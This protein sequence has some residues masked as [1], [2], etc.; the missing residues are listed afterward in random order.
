VASLSGL[1]AIAAMPTAIMAPEISPPGRCA[2]K[3]SAPPAVPITSVSSTWRALVRLG[4][5]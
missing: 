4:M 2:H 5:A 1:P 3:N